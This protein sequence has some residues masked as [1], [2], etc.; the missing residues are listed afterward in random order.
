MPMLAD[1]VGGDT[2]CDTHPLEPTA[3]TRV[4]IATLSFSNDERVFA[5]ALAWL[6]PCHVT[7]ARPR[8]PGTG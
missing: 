4:T 5:D 6:A 7:S 2:H 3:A 8:A 1:V